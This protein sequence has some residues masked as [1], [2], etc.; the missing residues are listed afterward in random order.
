MAN[1]K[2]NE[3]TDVPEIVEDE[4][5]KNAHMNYELVD[6]EVAQYA[7]ETIVE[8]DEETNRRLKLLIDKRV[9]AVMIDLLYPD[10]GQ[11]NDVLCLHHG[12]H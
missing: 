4:G 10:A 11:G 9:L 1:D 5:L 8:N 6:K 7:S 2:R 3:I 12:S